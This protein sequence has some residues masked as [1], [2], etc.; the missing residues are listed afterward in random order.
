VKVKEIMKRKVIHFSPNDSI[1]KVAKI[2][3]QKNISGAPVVEKGKVV[4][5]ISETDIIK[6]IRMKFPS[7]IAAPQLSLLIL[8]FLK[9]TF[10]FREEVKKV[11]KLRVKD[12]MSKK[13]V[14]ISPKASILEAAEKMEKFDV[15]RLP[16][17]E[18]GKLVGIISR[19]DLV[20]TLIR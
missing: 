3:S 6:F 5:I 8:N 15:Q 19:A 2:F 10:G 20:K 12:L 14:S 17:I 16:V 4:G 7:S 13:V 1:F 11:S 9:N 18:K